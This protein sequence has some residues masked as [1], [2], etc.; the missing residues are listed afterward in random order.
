M[1]DT[2]MNTPLAD[3]MR[4]GALICIVAAMCCLLVYMQLERRKGK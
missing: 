3:L 2:A 1:S 4:L